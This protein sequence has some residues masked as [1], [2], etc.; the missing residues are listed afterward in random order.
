M[1]DTSLSKKEK[2]A[3]KSSPEAQSPPPQVLE[4][5]DDSEENL[6]MHLKDAAILRFI[7]GLV[8]ISNESE[9]I[10]EFRKRANDPFWRSLECI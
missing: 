7:D 9:F 2:K 6:T 4:Y 3:S 8:K 1:A 10:S 5:Q